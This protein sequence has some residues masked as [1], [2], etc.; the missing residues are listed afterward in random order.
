MYM[1]VCANM[2]ACVHAYVEMCVHVS[3]C[4]HMYGYR[5]MCLC[6]CMYGC[7]HSCMHICMSARIDV[8]GMMFMYN[9]NPWA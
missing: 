8:C 6:A 5:Y 3:A 1:C 2:R 7:G 9:Y 4:V